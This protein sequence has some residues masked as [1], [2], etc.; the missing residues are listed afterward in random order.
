MRKIIL[1][2][3]SIGGFGVDPIYWF[4]TISK[5]LGLLKKT[6]NYNVKSIRVSDEDTRKNVK[7]AVA[8]SNFVH[9]TQKERGATA[10]FVGSKGKNF[11]KRLPA[12]RLNTDAKLETMRLT[13]RTI[14]TS[15][16]NAE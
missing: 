7:L 12:Q 9:E 4:D 6:E 10:G 14:G 11:T 15:A 1:G 2:A 5:K 8:I 13:L 3:N 16:L